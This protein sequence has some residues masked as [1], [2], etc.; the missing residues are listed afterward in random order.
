MLQIC[1]IVLKT[2]HYLNMFKMMNAVSNLPADDITAF[3][4][5]SQAASVWM[6]LFC[7]SFCL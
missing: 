7:V 2:I 5:T 1:D 4:T 6:E 3:C